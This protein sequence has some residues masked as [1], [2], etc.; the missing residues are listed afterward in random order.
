MYYLKKSGAFTLS[1]VIFILAVMLLLAHPARAEEGETTFYQKGVEA[2]RQENFSEALQHWQAGMQ[3]D[4]ILSYNNYAFLKYKGLGTSPN[5]Q[6]AVEL[7]L[8]AAQKGYAES[9]WH[10]GVAFFEGKG[11]EQNFVQAYAWSMCAFANAKKAFEQ[12]EGINYIAVQVMSATQETISELKDALT[13]EEAE[14]ARQ[15]SIHY[16]NEY[17]VPFWETETEPTP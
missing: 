8:Y 5:P 15:W 2:F 9:Q 7:W 13:E 1:G 12:T 10:L 14:Q 6:E 4:D 17:A 3:E 16:I 11:V